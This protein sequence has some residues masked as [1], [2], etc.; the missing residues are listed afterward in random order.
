MGEGQATVRLA[1]WQQLTEWHLSRLM[2]V[3][4]SISRPITKS[5]PKM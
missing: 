4:V 5:H 1:T 3:N 2:A